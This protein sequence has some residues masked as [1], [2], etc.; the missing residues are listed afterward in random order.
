LV[1][2]IVVFHNVIV[3]K[4]LFKIKL[5]YYKLLSCKLSAVSYQLGSTKADC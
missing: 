2:L 4:Y 5:H 3:S 1:F